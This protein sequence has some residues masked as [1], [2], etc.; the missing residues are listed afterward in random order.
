MH[1]LPRVVCTEDIMWLNGGCESEQEKK[2]GTLM[3]DFD[4]DTI[5]GRA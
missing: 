2:T 5:K 3:K 1:K 4:L